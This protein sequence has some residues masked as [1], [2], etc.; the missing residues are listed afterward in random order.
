MRNIHL[1][2]DPLWGEARDVPLLV[3]HREA[4]V[5]VPPDA[6]VVGSSESCAV[7]ALAWRSHPLWSFQSHPE[8]TA[9]FAANNAVPLDAA[10]EVRLAQG[11]ALVDRFLESAGYPAPG[12]VPGR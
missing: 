5:R 3:S 6:T 2:A 7:E 12:G 10:E 4:V 9:A 1:S 11:Q 8:A